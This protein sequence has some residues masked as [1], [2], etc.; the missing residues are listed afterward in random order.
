MSYLIAAHVGVHSA[1]AG[2]R[3]ATPLL[4][5]SLGYGTDVVGYLV[6]LFAVSQIVLAIPAGRFA[7]RHGLRLPLSC[8]AMMAS[9][10]TG[11]AVAWP[12]LPAL[13]I[14][15][16][17][18]GGAVGLSLITLQ[19]HIGR[20]SESEEQL[21]R[22][23]AWLS[24]AP[25]MSIFVGPLLAGL[26]IDALSF[27][28]AFAVLG[29][30]PLGAWLAARRSPGLLAGQAQRQRSGSPWS[31]WRKPAFRDLLLLN[32]LM[33]ASWDLH[34]FMVPVL[35]HERGLSA[36]W[37]GILLS[38]FA[39]AATFSR[40]AVPALARRAPEWMI[41]AGAVTLAAIILGVY[42]LIG[43]VFVMAL[44]SFLLGALLGSI[45]PSV[46]ILLHRIVPA[47]RQGDA[48]AMRLMMVN[49]SGISMPLLFGIAGAW[50]T[51]AGVFH[52]TAAIVTLGGSIGLVRGRRLSTLPKA[53][54]NPE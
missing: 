11:L 45:Q 54:S 8:A 37:I 50:I 44:C 3:M 48:I 24:I 53:S 49:A 22:G 40:L 27:R 4:G 41:V 42:P 31:L 34:G 51:V 47:H 35:G 12:A 20:T 43:N 1:M 38:L 9:A 5:L 7:D 29:L 25:S 32:W 14:A 52:A 17:C 10:G 26:V 33:T 36:S 46:M 30:L 15:A 18:L 2:L 39:L 19:R 13:C 23:L 16:L 6:A 28:A 21:R